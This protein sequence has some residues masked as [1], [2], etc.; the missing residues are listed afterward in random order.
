LA[1]VEGGHDRE[2]AVELLDGEPSW[3]PSAWMSRMLVG[4]A[5]LV[6]EKLYRRLR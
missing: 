6:L 2:N 3:A 1:N 4:R 5:A